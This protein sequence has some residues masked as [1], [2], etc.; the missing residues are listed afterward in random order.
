MKKTL[1]I[2]LGCAGLSLAA[3]EAR[4]VYTFE[5]PSHIQYNAAGNITSLFYQYDTDENLSF[6]A[7]IEQKPWSVGVAEGGWFVLSPGDNPK[8]IDNELAIFYMDFAGGDLYTYRY[9]GNLGINGQASYE[10]PDLFVNSYQD[11]LDVTDEA[12]VL[13]VGFNNL[14]IS[15]IAPGTFGPD[16]TGA[17][18][19]EQIGIWLHFAAIDSFAVV[20]GKITEF[21]TG[22]QS[23]YDVKYQDTTVS[24]SEPAGLAALGLLGVLGAGAV[25]QRRRQQAD[26]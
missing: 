25:R 3:A 12:G 24:V 2:V 23:W 14:D 17:S 26:A 1:G 21:F 19:G 18:F 20:D 15:D 6:A 4:T 11:V 22:V 9:D 5:G 8:A 7:T 13:N 16:W 10:D